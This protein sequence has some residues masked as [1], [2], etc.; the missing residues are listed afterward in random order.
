M[1]F[2]KWTNF[3]IVGL[4]NH[5]KT[6]I[7][8]SLINNNKNISG[9]VTSQH[10]ISYQNSL[11]FLNLEL[12]LKK[13]DKNTVFFIS[14][15]PNIHF[16]QIKKIISYG[17]NVIIEK[18]AFITKKEVDYIDGLLKMNN[19]LIVV[20]AFM[21]KYTILYQKFLSFWNE[22][23]M[24]IKFLN[25]NF[26][27]PD[28]PL[29]TFRDNRDVSSSCLYDLG[30]YGLSLLSEMDIDF[31]DLKLIKVVK[32]KYFIDKIHMSINIKGLDVIIKFGVGE[33]YNN[34][35]TA[36]TDQGISHIFSP[37][38]YG[39]SGKKNI[40]I[41]DSFDNVLSKKI[42]LDHNAFDVMLAI[43]MLDWYSDQ[44]ERFKKMSIVTQKLEEIS[45]QLD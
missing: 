26:Y 36:L 28:Y 25:I 3:C 35:V 8:P 19:K 45:T 42:F 24:K 20:E 30:C 40:V 22:N 7:I 1:K 10:N 41:R 12:S 34:S 29:N 15:P 32:Q 44:K 2:E 37:F 43:P 39:R 17:H 27:I 11:S 9:L 4:G 38:F 31:K 16:Y 13:L 23:K 5:A 6:K 33:E 14:T 21:Y 18:P